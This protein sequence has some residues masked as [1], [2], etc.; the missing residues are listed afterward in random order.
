LVEGLAEVLAELAVPTGQYLVAWL[1]KGKLA[2]NPY[3]TP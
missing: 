2:F 3:H 1:M